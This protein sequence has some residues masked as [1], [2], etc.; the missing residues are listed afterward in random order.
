MT[1]VIINHL[2][3]PENEPYLDA[4]LLCSPGVKKQ[5][6]QRM[7][8]SHSTKTIAQ[9]I[10]MVSVTIIKV[11]DMISTDHDSLAEKI[12]PIKH[13]HSTRIIVSKWWRSSLWYNGNEIFP[14][15]RISKYLRDI[16]ILG[17]K[18]YFRHLFYCFEVDQNV[19]PGGG[20][21]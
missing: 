11:N 10:R 1:C 14:R 20:I 9:S 16:G 19:A 5:W 12:I 3:T 7:S 4:D 18:R 17:K 21:P 15:E 6:V 2:C 13:S 8:L